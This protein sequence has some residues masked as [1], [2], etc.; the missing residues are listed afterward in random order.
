MKKKYLLIEET[1]LEQIA[2]PQVFATIKAARDWIRKD[3]KDTIGDN[4]Q[5]IGEPETWGNTYYICEIKQVVR[6]VPR[7]SVSV[8]IELMEVQP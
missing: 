1:G 4:F 6:P 7:I 5:D 2:M 3:A 8:K